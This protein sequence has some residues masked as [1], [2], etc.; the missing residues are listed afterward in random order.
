MG[1]TAPMALA[2]CHSVALSHRLLIWFCKTLLGLLEVGDYFFQLTTA[3]FFFFLS[4]LEGKLQSATIEQKLCIPWII[5]TL[6]GFRSNSLKTFS[7]I[8]A[9]GSIQTRMLQVCFTIAVPP[10]PH[11]HS[12]P[13]ARRHACKVLVHQAEGTTALFVQP[14]KHDSWAIIGDHFV[15]TGL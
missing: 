14:L 12:H 2:S 9:C 8:W 1:T 4:C 5:M 10:L 15:F 3:L 6:S 7:P 11:T 13:C